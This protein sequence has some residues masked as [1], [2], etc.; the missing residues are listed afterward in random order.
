MSDTIKGFEKI[1][2]QSLDDIFVTAQLIYHDTN[3][4]TD[5]DQQL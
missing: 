2:K 4:S 1:I 5:I 3:I